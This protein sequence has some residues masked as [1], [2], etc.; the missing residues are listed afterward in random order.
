MA[1]L[2]NGTAGLR[3]AK[4]GPGWAAAALLAALAVALPACGKAGASNTTSHRGRNSTVIVSLTFDDGDESQYTLGFQHGL[5]PFGLHGTFYVATGNTGVN[6]GA[7]SWS[8]LSYL[9]R[10]GNDVGGHTVHHI[11]LTRSSY[12]L[13]RKTAEVCGSYQ[14]L[15]RHGLHP[16]SFSYPYGAYNTADE[17]VAAKCGFQTARRAGGVDDHGP[18][19]GPVYAE[20]IPAYDPYAIR[21]AYNSGKAA[22]L[23]VGNLQRAVTAAAHRGGGWVVLVFHDICS[24]SYD[25][26]DYGYC[27]HSW[28]SIQLGG[29]DAFAEWL[30]HAGQ[31]GGAPAGTVVRTVRQVVSGP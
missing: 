9:Y 2:A 27:T 31:P 4:A 18:G 15:A 21:T 23:V 13:A 8:Q 29:F 6:P 14:D 3:G 12:S 26:A 25:P 5:L 7:M 11:D 24:V 20:T 1:A 10:R 28:G 22:P 30:A 17:R 16:V 19:A